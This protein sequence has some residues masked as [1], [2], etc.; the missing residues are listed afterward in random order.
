MAF[1]DAQVDAEL[2]V[3]DAERGVAGTGY[4]D[5]AVGEDADGADGGGVSVVDVDA[6]SDLGVYNNISRW[7]D[8]EKRKRKWRASHTETQKSGSRTSATTDLIP[9]MANLHPTNE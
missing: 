8:K 2:D 3:P 9:R 4:G 1:E 5:G 6:L 7:Y